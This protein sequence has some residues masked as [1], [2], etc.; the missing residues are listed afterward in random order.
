MKLL[1]AIAKWAGYAPARRAQSGFAAADHSRLTAALTSETQFINTTLRYQL[2]T[3]RARS[4]QAAQNN[5]Y[6]KRFAQMVVD[7]VC[8]P[9]PFRLQAKVKFNSG[10]LDTVANKAIEREWGAWGRVGACELTGKWSWNTAQ[11]L[12]VRCLAVDGELLLRKYRGPDYGRHGYQLQIIDVDRLWEMKNEQLKGGGAIHMGVEV[13][14]TGRPLAYHLLKRKPAQWQLGYVH[15]TERVPAD[16]IIHLF[17]PDFAEQSRGIPWIYAAL[18]NLVHLGA[19]EEAAVIAARVGAAQMGVIQSPDGGQTLANSASQ[20]A[21]GNPQIDAEPGSFPVLPPGYE[22]TGW[23]P[24]Y[25]DAAIGPFIKACLRGISAGVGVAYHNLANDLEGVNYSSARIGEL[26]ERDAWM[27]LQTFTIEHLHEPLYADWLRTQVLA[28]TLPFDP[29]RLDKYR[30]VYWQPRR[31]AWV[32]PLKEVRANI[33]AIEA[34]LKSR[35]RTIAEQGDDIEDTFDEI[36]QEEALA[37]EKGIDLTPAPSTPAADTPADGADAGG[38]GSAS[39][40][41]AA[42]NKSRRRAA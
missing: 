14:P 9:V 29:S 35:T 5:P 38:D 6:A 20:D 24:K 28:G 36:A 17:V 42:G 18:L 22:M 3:L 10:K 15:E 12:L 19:F 23:N 2:R 32:D 30:D 27:G 16:E 37:D 31:W 1:D 25:P 7:N 11:R 33:E 26:D 34:R 41:S 4:R 8:G 39:G 13:D 21:Q 40:D